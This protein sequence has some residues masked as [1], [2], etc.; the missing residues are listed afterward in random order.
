MD[1][2]DPVIVRYFVFYISSKECFIR[3]NITLEVERR[4]GKRKRE[5]D[6]GVPLPL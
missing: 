1:K 4:E 6:A 5:E 3:V 2:R